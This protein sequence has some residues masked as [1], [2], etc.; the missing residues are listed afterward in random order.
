MTRICQNCGRPATYVRVNA[1]KYKGKKKRA[2][3]VGRN[4]HDLC[5]VCWHNLMTSIRMEQNNRS[6]GPIHGAGTDSRAETD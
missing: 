5:A 6:G 2:D 4:D 1:Q 3:R